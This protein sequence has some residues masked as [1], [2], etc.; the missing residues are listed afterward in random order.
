MRNIRKILWK[1][2]SSCISSSHKLKPQQ[3]CIT[4]ISDCHNKSTMVVKNYRPPGKK[5][6]ERCPPPAVTND[7]A[8]SEQRISSIRHIFGLHQRHQQ[9]VTPL[10]AIWQRP[11]QRLIFIC[12]SICLSMFITHSSSG[13]AAQR[14]RDT[15]TH[16]FEHILNSYT[17][18]P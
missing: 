2:P 15:H 4:I 5:T 6:L 12:V 10:C 18:S 14:C 8:I 17:N 3:Q 11:G 13:S 7:L 9:K 16:R 1:S